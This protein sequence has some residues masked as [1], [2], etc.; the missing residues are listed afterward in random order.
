MGSIDRTYIAVHG[1]ESG[2]MSNPAV[3]YFE[4]ERRRSAGEDGPMG[5]TGHAKD[6]LQPIFE[7]EATSELGFDGIIGRSNALRTVLHEIK[8]VAPTDSTVLIYGGL[9]WVICG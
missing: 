9:V 4:D 5:H 8:T 3:R 2:F 1:D 7:D 6:N